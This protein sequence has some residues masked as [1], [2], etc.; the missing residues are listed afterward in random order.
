[1]ARNRLM[2][3]ST[4]ARDVPHGKLVLG[5]VD[6]AY[7]TAPELRKLQPDATIVTTSVNGSRKADVIDRETGNV[8][9]IRAAAI[10]HKGGAHTVYVNLAGL[11]DVLHALHH[12]HLD[13]TPI[14][15]AHWT[16]KRH[17]CG[18]RCLAP[19]RLPYKPNIIGTQFADPATSGGHYDI[20]LV[21]PHWPGVDPARPRKPKHRP[22]TRKRRHAWMRW[23]NSWRHW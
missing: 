9:A 7:V 17:I 22:T 4:T 16:G 19:Y 6:G 15:T 10:I 20:S 5:Y 1:M 13:R 23:I 2:Y 3:D 11:A 14:L 12:Y 18:R 8:D 21:K